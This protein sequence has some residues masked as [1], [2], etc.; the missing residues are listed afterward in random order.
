MGLLSILLSSHLSHAVLLVSCREED[1]ARHV[2]EAGELHESATT[3]K[4]AVAISTLVVTAEL[5][6][7]NYTRALGE[8][9]R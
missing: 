5:A 9:K 8:E 6:R 3:D 4:D 1:A 7:S 2:L